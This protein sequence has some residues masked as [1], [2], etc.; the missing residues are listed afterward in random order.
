MARAFPDLEPPLALTPDN[1]NR[2]FIREV[3]EEVRRERV[4]NLWSRW[5]VQIV[6]AIL[7][8][9]VLAGL[10]LWWRSHR[11]AQRGV[12]GEQLQAAYDKLAADDT[13]GASAALAPIARDGGPGYRSLARMTQADIA[14]RGKD[15]ATAARL[16]GTVTADGD[17]AAPLR[18]L[19]LVRQ[20]AAEYDTLKPEAI[21]A[22][23][24]T[25]AVKGNAYFGSA[26]EMVALAYLRMGRR[27][28]A[29]ALIG[30]IA[31]DDTVPATIRQRAVQMVSALG[32]NT[33]QGTGGPAAAPQGQEKPAT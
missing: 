23:L 29:A 21:V 6:A 4:A 1:S 8:A 33:P 2:A 30:Q 27:D 9:L 3:D 24:R 19:A 17:V 15:T 22:R 11:E 32:A 10:A 5:G 28:L 20:T 13:K 25:L 7:A 12:E 16:F 31:G 26:G 14:L 18:D